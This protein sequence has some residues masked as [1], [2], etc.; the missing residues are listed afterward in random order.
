MA[1]RPNEFLSTKYTIPY[2]HAALTATASP[3]IFKA[4]E[5][6]RV[7][8]ARYGN[9]TGLAQNGSNSYALT[10]SKTGSVAVATGANTATTAIPAGGF[11]EFTLSAVAGAVV[12]EV[13]DVLSFT[14][15]RT[16]TQTLPVGRLLVDLAPV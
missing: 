14:A 8:G 13:G 6:T 16:G 4:T 5:R 11:T 10:M 9:A 15:T 12:L 7:M 2:D 1:R 3:E